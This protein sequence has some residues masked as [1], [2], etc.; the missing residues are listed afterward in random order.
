VVATDQAGNTGQTHL[1]YGTS[2]ADVL[3]STS[4]SEIFTG[5]GGSDTF[6]FSGNFGQDTITDF[7]AATD[8][9]QLDQSAFTNFASVLSHATQVGGDV[10][11]AQDAHNTL[12][13]NDTTLSQLASHN[14]HLV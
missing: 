12:T 3:S 2:G 8:T 7:K 6:V 11:I 5:Q 13:I 4:A 9:I 14:F 10:M 1:I